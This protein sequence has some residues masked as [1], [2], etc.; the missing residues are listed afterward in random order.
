MEIAEEVVAQ[1]APCKTH[2]LNFG[3]VCN[4]LS[5]DDKECDNDC[6]RVGGWNGGSCKNQKCDCDC[7]TSPTLKNNLAMVSFIARLYMFLE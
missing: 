6:R 5:G 1:N 4:G 3:S 2:N 7:W